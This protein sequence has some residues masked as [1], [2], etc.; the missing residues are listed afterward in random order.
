MPAVPEVPITITGTHRCSST[1]KNLPQLIGWS[2]YCGSIRPPIEVP[3]TTL[4]K[5]S[6]TSAS[7]K[8][9]VA[10]PR[11]PRKVSAWSLTAVLVGG[12]IDPDRERHR[13]G[14]QDRRER[15]DEG[16]EHAVAD[17]RVDR[18]VVF[19]GVAEVAA[20]QAAEPDQV[21]LPP[22]PVEAVDLAQVLDL[23]A[24]DAL[25]LG[26]QLGDVAL[27]IVARRQLDDDEGDQADREQRRHHDQET[28]DDVAKHARLPVA[29]SRLTRRD[30]GAILARASSVAPRNRKRSA[31]PLAGKPRLSGAGRRDLRQTASAAAGTA[32]RPGRPVVL[33]PIS[34]ASRPP[35][36]S[37]ASAAAGQRRSSA[38][39]LALR[40]KWI[41]GRA[42]STTWSTG[43][44]R[45]DLG[46]PAGAGGRRGWR[47]R[48][49]GAPAPG[50]RRAGGRGS[51]R[52]GRHRPSAT[53][54]GPSRRARAPRCRRPPAATSSRR[55]R[56]RGRRGAASPR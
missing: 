17:H 38:L 6:S 16:Q 9:G 47:A 2:R 27:E 50:P 1:E 36:R 37:A 18:Q 41:G 52:P 14:E 35:E 40:R 26:L 43:A 34:A 20:E 11:K 53:P 23:L 25:A 32:P 21:L 45:L 56:R 55:T 15:D 7:R 49:P 8:F 33:Q 3:K 51:A 29:P 39:K 22:R 5:Y 13:P 12:G 30:A 54:H 48:G 46:R 10:R 28:M 4:A 42:R 24:L 19:E 31:L 44:P